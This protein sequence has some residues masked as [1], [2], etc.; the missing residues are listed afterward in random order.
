[1]K[2]EPSLKNM[3]YNAILEDIF[4]MEYQPGQI[5]NEKTLV[6]KYNCSKSPVREAL[7]TLCADNVLR[8]IPRYGYEV[9]RL[10]IEDIYEMIQYRYILEGGILRERYQNITPLHFQHLAEIDAKCKLETSDAWKHWEYNTEFHLKL[11][12][13]CGNNYALKELTRCMSRLKR[14]YAQFYWPKWDQSLPPSDTRYHTQIL[15]CLQNNDLSGALQYLKE[16]L[17][18]FGGLGNNLLD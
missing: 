3:I 11:I 2:S 13:F 1:M 12:G 6:E 16:D 5:L 7:L 15:S 4:S 8:N 17:N 18:D 10:S 14:A 9:V